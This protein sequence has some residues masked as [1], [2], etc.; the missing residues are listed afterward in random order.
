M[1]R[2]CEAGAV[3]SICDCKGTHG[4]PRESVIPFW[5]C[6]RR[7]LRASSGRPTG[8]LDIGGH[9]VVAWYRH[10]IPVAQR[11]YGLASCVGREEHDVVVGSPDARTRSARTTR[12]AASG[13]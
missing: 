6:D 4:L 3:S 5:C 11:G 10:A 13:P 2:P 9:R 12:R 1:T 8:A 7:A